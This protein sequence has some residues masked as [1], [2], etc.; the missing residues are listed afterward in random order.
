MLYV[1][2]IPLL[3]VMESQRVE[4]T[5]IQQCSACKINIYYCI[6]ICNKK[7]QAW[8]WCK[9]NE[10]KKLLPC[11]TSMQ[12]E[13]ELLRALTDHFLI[14]SK[15][16]STLPSYLV[17][18]WVRFHSTVSIGVSG[19]LSL[20]V[21]VEFHTSWNDRNADLLIN[22]QS[23]SGCAAYWCWK[24]PIGLFLIYHVWVWVCM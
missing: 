16:Q 17:T 6:Q 24:E 15:F 19:R 1:A 11:K 4:V 14:R 7:G 18:S 10:I 5:E 3:L 9:F 21:S 12:T 2:R 8:F 13:Q 23:T 20:G 22:T